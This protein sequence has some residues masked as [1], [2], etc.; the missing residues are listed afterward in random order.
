MLNLGDAGATHVCDCMKVQSAHNP[1]CY[2][3]VPKAV[4][5]DIPCRQVL[6]PSRLHHP[7]EVVESSVHLPETACILGVN[8]HGGRRNWFTE[9][10]SKVV[11]V[12]VLAEMARHASQITQRYI[13]ANDERLS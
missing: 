12:R 8:S 3:V 7:F 13:G 11:G 4:G 10:S 2:H 1:L 5:N 9:L 6:N